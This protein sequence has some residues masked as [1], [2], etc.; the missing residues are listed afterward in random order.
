MV[1]SSR[2]SL[3]DGRTLAI[4]KVSA[5]EELA[6]PLE[7]I[8]LSASH[9]VLVLVGG[10]S[11]ISEVDFLRIQ[12]LFVNILAPLV[13]ELGAYVVDGGTDAGIMRLMGDCS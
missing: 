1:Y 4:A 3:T 2:I 11:R 7:Q 9:P 8:G 6:I 12:N 13:Q 10:A 5:I